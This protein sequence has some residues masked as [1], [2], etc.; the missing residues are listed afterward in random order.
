LRIRTVRKSKLQKIFGEKVSVAAGLAEALFE[1][2]E[3]PA[4]S[5]ADQCRRDK[6]DKPIGRTDQRPHGGH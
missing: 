6:Y 5:S 2:C 1:E 3:D 4:R